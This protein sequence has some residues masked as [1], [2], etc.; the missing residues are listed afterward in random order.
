MKPFFFLPD[1]HMP[2]VFQSIARLIYYSNGGFSFTELYSGMPVYV[3]RY[4]TK[5]INNIKKKEKKQIED[6]KSS[7]GGQGPPED[8]GKVMEKMQK[9]G[10]AEN[11]FADSEKATSEE[12]RNPQKEAIR[13]S[14]KTKS[15]KQQKQKPDAESFDI[16]ASD[17]EDEKPPKAEDLN[18]LIDKLK[19]EG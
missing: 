13:Q 16:P 9:R 3:R 19:Q 17:K 10:D 6:G 1:D 8:I 15:N 18:Q 2:K 4:M 7:S 11:P 5:E 12:R 14:A